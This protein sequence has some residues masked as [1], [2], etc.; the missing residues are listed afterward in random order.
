MKLISILIPAYNHANY[1]TQTLNSILKDSYPNK[2][3]IIIDDGSSDNTDL[4]I[5][6]W[7]KEHKDKIKIKY[8]SRKNQGLTKTLNELLSMSEGEYITTLASDD[9]L[10]DKGLEKRYNYLEY[11]VDKYAVFSDCIVVDSNSNILYKSALFELK[12]TNRANLN[13]DAGIQKEFIT[14]FSMPGPVLLIKREYYTKFGEYNESMYMEDFDLYLTLAAK[15]LIGFL[16]EKVS[17]YRIH[18]TNMSSSKSSNY[19]KLLIDSKKT[20]KLH[21]NSFK[22]YHK[23]LLYKEILKFSIRIVLNRV[24]FRV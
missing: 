16:D 15:N 14:N 12:S 7:I 22:G 11:H 2:E 5:K 24:G 19:L 9:Y 18:Q 8:K 1:V 13:T 20:L 21:K 23:F 10:L 3:I 4:V 6:E 17:A